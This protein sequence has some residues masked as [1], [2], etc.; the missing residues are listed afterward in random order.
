MG[1]GVVSFSSKINKKHSINKMNVLY[2]SDKN[3]DDKKEKNISKSSKITG[4]RYRLEGALGLYYEKN[5]SYFFQSIAFLPE[6][7]AEISKKFDI[8]FGPKFTIDLSENKSSNT[9]NVEIIAI[10]GM[11]SDFNFKIKENVKA[12]IGIEAGLGGGIKTYN[13]EFLPGFLIKGA[14]GIKI[15]NRY[16]VGI[17]SGIT[18]KGLSG[19]EFG[20]TFK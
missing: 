15:N 12:Y 20:Y 4:P 19:I 2:S 1:G 5:N 17:Y 3:K 8:T 9:N 10:L 6:W 11:E 7:K 13:I 16:N 14:L 18:S